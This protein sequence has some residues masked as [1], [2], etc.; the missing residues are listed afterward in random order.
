MQKRKPESAYLMSGT[1]KITPPKNRQASSSVQKTLTARALMKARVGCLT[2][3]P[4]PNLEIVAACA[5][6]LNQ[7]ITDDGVAFAPAVVKKQ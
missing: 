1:G 7:R 6:L 5:G 4:T 3:V 2:G